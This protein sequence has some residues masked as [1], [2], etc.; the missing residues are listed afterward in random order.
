[1]EEL[2]VSGSVTQTWSVTPTGQLQVIVPNSGSQVIY[3]LKVSK[4]G[5]ELTQSIPI[6]VQLTCTTPWFF[7]GANAPQ[8]AGCPSGA[9]STVTGKLQIFERGVMVNINLSG[10]NR[11]YGLNATGGRFMVYQSG[12]DGVSTTNVPC[13]D[14][15]AGLV[16]PQDVFNWAY[17]NTLGTQGLWCD[18][19]SGIGW[20]TGNA[21]LTVN[22]TVQYEQNNTTFYIGIPGYGVVRI[23]PGEA[24][25][26]TWQRLNVQ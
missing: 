14:A 22:Y 2:S 3:R 11:V 17:H 7:G 18:A 23:V 9:A 6:Q 13:G 24:Q 4:D 10:Q 20:G 16:S 5:Q 26:G 12:W 19:T 15:P 8:G 25:T 1:M 21:S